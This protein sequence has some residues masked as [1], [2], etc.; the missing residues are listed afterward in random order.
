MNAARVLFLVAG[1][2]AFGQW[3]NHPSANI[4]RTSDGKPDLAAPAP[5]TPDGKPDLS[6]IWNSNFNPKIPPG[7]LLASSTLPG[8]DLQ[9]W[10]TAAAPIPMTPWAEAVFNERTRNFARDMPSARCLPHGIPEGMMLDTFK[11]MQYPGTTLVLYEEF[12]RFRQIFTDGRNQPQEMNPAWLGYSVGKWDGDALVVETRGLNDRSWLDP[13]GHPHS[14]QL[15]ITERFHRKSLG[16]MDLEV[17]FEDPVAYRE[18]WSATLRFEL[19]PDTE[20]IENVCD[21]EKDR[22]HLVGRSPSDDTTTLRLPIETLRE[23][24]G[25][26]GNEPALEIVLTQSGL[27]MAGMLLVPKSESQFTTNSGIVT[28]VKDDQGRVEKVIGEFVS[29]EMFEIPRRR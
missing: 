23:Y 1:M 2:P 4:P 21:N 26:Y 27:V 16:Q 15:R 28:F 13:A 14:D 29:G 25:T 19:A 18:P 6:G 8:F 9:A 17:T 10:R 3:I 7:V 24:A 5:R 20:L 22:Q 11:I 12:A